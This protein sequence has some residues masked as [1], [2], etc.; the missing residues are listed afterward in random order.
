[1]QVRYI[2]NTSGKY[3]AFVSGDNLFNPSADWIGVIRNGNEVFNTDGLYIGIVLDDDRIVRDRTDLSPKSTSHPKRP[4]R[5]LR[6]MRPLRRLRMPKVQSPFEDTF[7]NIRGVIKKLTPLFELRN[8]DH[9]L[10]ASIFAADDTFIGLISKDEYRQD[11]ISNT[12]GPY[13]GEFSQLSI[14]NEFGPYGGIFGPMSPFNDF[15]NM[16]PR[17]VKN[18]TV[19]GYLTTNQLFEGRIDTNEF[20]AWLNLDRVNAA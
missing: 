3:V 2:F 5:P 17:I 18:E 14:F 12:F 4:N 19:V 16:P 7:A 20:T 9:I 13:G 1:M 15:S 10:G 6:P 8:F 11:S